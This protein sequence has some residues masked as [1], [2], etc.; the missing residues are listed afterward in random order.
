M[1]LASVLPLVHLLFLLHLSLEVLEIDEVGSRKS[2]NIFRA[3]TLP[4]NVRTRTTYIQKEEEMNRRKGR[5]RKERERD[6]HKVE[7]K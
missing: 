1:E 6:G 7:G 5:K 3:P 2:T 4:P